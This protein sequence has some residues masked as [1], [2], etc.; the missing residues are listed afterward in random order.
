MEERAD[1]LEGLSE[2]EIAEIVLDELLLDEKFIEFSKRSDSSSE[3][4][5]AESEASAS[6]SGADEDTPLRIQFGFV[7]YH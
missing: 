2:N 7:S 5:N 4:P 6:D 3:V 1:E